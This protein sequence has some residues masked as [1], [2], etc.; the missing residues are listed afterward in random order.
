MDPGQPQLT[1]NFYSADERFPQI[2]T[3]VRREAAKTL[4]SEAAIRFQKREIE[5]GC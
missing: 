3:N 5:Y 2:S 4:F 1:P